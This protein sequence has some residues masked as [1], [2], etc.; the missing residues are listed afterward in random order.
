MEDIK[1]LFFLGLYDRVVSEKISVGDDERTFYYLRARINLNQFDFVESKISNKDTSLKKGIYMLLEAKKNS[2]VSS[3]LALLDEFKDDI[4]VN[5]NIY[6]IICK[7]MIYIQLKQYTECLDI[8]NNIEHPEVH[9]LKIQTYLL[10][11]KYELADEEVE[12]IESPIIKT[13]FNGL[14]SL[15]KDSSSAESAL[16]SLQDMI[17]RFG[18][19]PFLVNLI[20]CCHFKLQQWD[21]LQDVLFKDVEKFSSDPS[22]IINSTLAL[23]RVGDSSKVKPQ[24]D[25][26]KKTKCSYTD[27]IN[28]MLKN[29]D[30]TVNMLSK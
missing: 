8:M 21:S 22:I 27:N 19:S 11:N 5:D 2:S 29:F 25:V 24:I 13:A 18:A 26:L 9:L 20:S 28:D 14:V 1:E 4:T 30:E 12:S 23:Q 7:A 17:D 3:L 10:M 16:F 15:F 6:F